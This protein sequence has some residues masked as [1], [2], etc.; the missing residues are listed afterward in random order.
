MLAILST[1]IE[2]AQWLSEQLERYNGRRGRYQSALLFET[3]AEFFAAVAANTFDRFIIDRPS[4]AVDIARRIKERHPTCL[5]AVISDNA[6]DAVLCYGAHIELVL[7]SKDLEQPFEM[8][9]M[10]LAMV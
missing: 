4:G 2:N 5:V 3:E 1:T 9:S 6:D 7:T 10:R 8:L